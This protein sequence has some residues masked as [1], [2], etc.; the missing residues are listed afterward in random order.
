MSHERLKHIKENLMSA[1]E[2]QVCNLQ[3]ADCEELGEAI[4]MLK[5]IEE[6]LYF[7]T[8]TEAMEKTEKQPTNGGGEKN[9]HQQ[10]MYYSEPYYYNGY[11]NPGTGGYMMYAQGGNGSSGSR[12]GNGSS[13]TGNSGS[14]SSYY[15]EPMM[16]RDYREGRSP[17][18]RK[19]YLEAKEHK[20]DKAPQLKELE[21]YMQELTSDMVDMIQEAT[22]E[23]KQ[24]LEKKI[25][26]LAAKIGQ[27][28]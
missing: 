15:Q 23:E 11:S 25:S 5:D 20:G 12:G 19:M 14:S 16:E 17:M 21:R 10:Y 3:E 2:G 26:A 27:M 18:S 6:A 4:D 13:S 1:I 22:S 28:K 24:Y 9:G 8:I 7:C